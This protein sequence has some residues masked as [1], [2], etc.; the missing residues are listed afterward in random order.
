[1]SSGKIEVHEIGSAKPFLVAGA[2]DFQIMLDGDR[3]GS[4]QAVELHGKSGTLLFVGHPGSPWVKE[5]LDKGKGR[6][7]IITADEEKT[8][9]TAYEE[10]VVFGPLDWAVSID[11]I[12]TEVVIPFEL[13]E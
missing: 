2:V 3:I 11:D 1:M 5:V 12:V 8:I 6:L 4:V 13:E 10:D 9:E 7:K